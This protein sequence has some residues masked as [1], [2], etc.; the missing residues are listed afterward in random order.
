MFVVAQPYQFVKLNKSAGIPISTTHTLAGAVLGVGRA[1]GIGALNMGVVGRIFL[2]WVITLPVG[3][4]L[5][6]L[7]FFL[8]RAIFG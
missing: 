3:A 7:F 5:S 2:S 8:L 1:R 6:I 4:A